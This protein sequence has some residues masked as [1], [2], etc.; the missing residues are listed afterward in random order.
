MASPPNNPSTAGTRTWTDRA[1]D[2][3]G[4]VSLETALV[5]MVLVPGML[6]LFHFAAAGATNESIEDAAAEALEVA[7]EL[8]STDSDA[9]HAATTILSADPFVA[10]YTIDISTGAGTATVTVTANAHQFV[11]FLDTTFERTVSGPIERFIAEPDR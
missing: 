4:A 11:P 10:G 7:T 8:G 5:M 9:R 1:R 3:R 6:V 2:D